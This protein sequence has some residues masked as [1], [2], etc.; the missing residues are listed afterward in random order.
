MV[1]KVYFGEGRSATFGMPNSPIR[2]L[3]GVQAYQLHGEALQEANTG[4]ARGAGD[5]HNAA[6]T[7]LDIH[8]KLVEEYNS[9]H[10]DA[11]VTDPTLRDMVAGLTRATG[12][13]IDTDRRLPKYYQHHK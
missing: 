3:R 2:K 8:K 12:R 5:L 11:D 10:P 13:V 1:E 9:K 7:E 6:H 4:S